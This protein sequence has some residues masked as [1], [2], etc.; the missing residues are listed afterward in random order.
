[1][2]HTFGNVITR[3]RR[4]LNLNPCNPG[5]WVGTNN[6]FENCQVK[7]LN[8]SL[9]FTIMQRTCPNNYYLDSCRTSYHVTGNHLDVIRIVI[10]HTWH[11]SQVSTS[12]KY[13][14]N[15]W[16]QQVIIIRAPVTNKKEGVNETKNTIPFRAFFEK[17]PDDFIYLNYSNFPPLHHRFFLQRNIKTD[18]W[19]VLAGY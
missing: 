14:I 5:R 2:K 8:L 15:R 1:M 18:W 13:I 4:D 12:G 6:P 16:Y 7:K 3:Q 17:K 19:T 10:W 11:K 9:R